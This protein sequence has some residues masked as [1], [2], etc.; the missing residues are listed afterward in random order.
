M[1]ISYNW[2]KQYLNFDHSPDEISEILT[3][4]GMEIKGVTKFGEELEQIVVAQII[5][6]K[7]HPRADKLSVCQVDDGTE[8]KQVICGAPNC[9]VNQKIAFAPIG[10][11]IG[12]FKIKKVNLRGEESFGMICSEKELGISENHDGIMVLDEKAPLGESLSSFLNDRFDT[13]FEAE[14]TPNRPDLLGIIG[15]ARDVAAYLKINLNIPEITYSTGKVKIEDFLKLENNEPELCSRYTARIIQ[16]VQVKDSPEWLQRRLISVGLRPINNIV[17]IT[18][19]VM[20][21]FG[22][23]LHAFDYEKI[24]GKKIIIR[25]ASGNE[26]FPALD[27]NIYELQENDLV[28][29]DASKP[30]AIAGVIGGENSHITKKTKTVVIEAANF[31]YSSIRKTANKFKIQTD[32]SHRFERDLADETAEIVSRR[33]AQLILEI[34][35]GTLLEG[36]LD[37][38]PNPESERIVS[39]RPSRARK[40]LTIDLSKETIQKHLENLGLKQ[41]DEE[42]DL[43]QFKIPSFRKDLTREIDL[44]EEIIR[45]HGYNNL[46]TFLKPQKIMDKY[47]FYMKREVQDFL[48]NCGFSEVVNWSFSDPNYL[49]LMKIKED[50]ERRNV[51]KIKNPLGSSFSIMRSMLLPGILKNALFNINHGKHDLKLFELSKTFIKSEGKLANERFF[52]TGLMTGNLSPV[53]WKEPVKKV[54]FYDIKGI[55]EDIL[56]ILGLSGVEFSNSKES[57]YQPGLAAEVS[58][59]NSIIADFGK[60]DPKI[61][62]NFE[63]EQPVFAFDINLDKIFFLHKKKNPEFNAIPKYPPVLRDI[64]FII[65]NEYKLAE[66]K[67]EIFKVNRKLIKKVIVFD[68]YTG[69]NIKNGYRSLTFNLILSSDTKTLT[70]EFVN[71]LIQKII[72]KLQTRFNIE[73]R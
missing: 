68:E 60:L 33:T 10:T 53:Y 16:N 30:I 36:K 25:R 13:C 3:Y 26:K 2:L 48:V 39:I 50:D 55:V 29:A 72:K 18:N 5:E 38:Y 67:E 34:A 27:E 37:S 15:I 57:Y 61:A 17:D 40:L 62:Q 71:G 59:K 9:A 54:D 43:L 44:I 51:V 31:L 65:P 46:E 52:V 45:M 66:I 47:S 19:F 20:M 69:K 8:I 73:M 14:I 70:D 12:E 6:K 24:E 32:S 41:V 23:P 4:L 22:H 56:E 35:G 49:D 7:Q 21:E 11:S 1:N 58:Y 42:D 64:S 28:I 63:I